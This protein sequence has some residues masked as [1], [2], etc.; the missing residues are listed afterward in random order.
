MLTQTFLIVERG[1]DQVLPIII[2]F[3]SQ[4]GLKVLL[5]FDLHSTRS[6]QQAYPCPHHGTEQC[7]CQMIVLL[8]YDNEGEP[9]TLFLHGSNGQTRLSFDE[10]LSIDTSSEKIKLI[11]QALN[12]QSMHAFSS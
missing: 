6:D 12:F 1:C 3:L 7:D 11:K 8:I 10:P 9:M 5:T 4:R 2:N